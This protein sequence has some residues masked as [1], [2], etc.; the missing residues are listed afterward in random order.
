MTRTGGGSA[1]RRRIVPLATL[2]FRLALGVC[3]ALSLAAL[4]PRLVYLARLGAASDARARGLLAADERVSPY[5]AAGQVKWRRELA[6]QAS[7]GRARASG[8][9]LAWAFFVDR[10]EQVPPGSR[11]LLSRPND[12]LYQFGNFLWYPS[13]LEVAPDVTVALADGEDLRRAAVRRDCTE[14][15]WLRENGYSGCVAVAGAELQLHGIGA[16]P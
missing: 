11:I 2:A 1:D 12:A 15:D 14:R 8:L 13:R 9:A 10:R 3:L 7:E 6:R 16:A 5:A 4:V